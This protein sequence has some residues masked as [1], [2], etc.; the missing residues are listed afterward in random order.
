LVQIPLTSCCSRLINN[1]SPF[2]S[3]FE[4][5]PCIVYPFVK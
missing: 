3:P 4:K 2:R 1:P 5:L